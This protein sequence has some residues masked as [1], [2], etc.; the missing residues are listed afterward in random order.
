MDEILKDLKRIREEV[1]E[2]LN[3]TLDS[4][5]EL[6][7]RSNELLAEVADSGS[8]PLRDHLEKNNQ[9]LETL[10]AGVRD[11]VALNNA[12]CA[13]LARQLTVLPAKRFDLMLESVEKRLETLEADFLRHTR[14][15]NNHE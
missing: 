15:G 6:H 9:L 14:Q 10:I 8:E 13:E 5:A 4:A 11:T 12:R 7:A 3:Q 2:R 1:E